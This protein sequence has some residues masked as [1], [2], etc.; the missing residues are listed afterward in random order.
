MANKPPI[1]P[2]EPRDAAERALVGDV[3]T[4]MRAQLA[5]ISARREALTPGGFDPELSAAA[6]AL[7]KVLLATAAER[8]Q[9]TKSAVRE[10]AAIPV[11][12]I[13]AFLRTIPEAQRQDIVRE[14]LG[15]DDGEPLL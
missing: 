2:P 12:E 10:I 6:A 11:P 7:G 13:V 5:V 14:I 1:Q 8:R 15:A 3:V 4:E 9:Q